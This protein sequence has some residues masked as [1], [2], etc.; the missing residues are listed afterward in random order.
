[1]LELGPL[2]VQSISIQIGHFSYKIK[3]TCDQW[4]PN[5]TMH[6]SHLR[7]HPSD[8]PQ[9]TQLLFG[10]Q[11]HRVQMKT[12]LHTTPFSSNNGKRWHEG[13]A[14]SFFCSWFAHTLCRE[15]LCFVSASRNLFPFNSIG[16]YC[17]F[18]WEFFK[19][20]E[21]ELLHG[22]KR[23][24]FSTAFPE[25]RLTRLG[26]YRKSRCFFFIKGGWVDKW[27]INKF[28]HEWVVCWLGDIF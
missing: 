16:V 25:F 4:I 8:I 23:K 10:N 18:T 15:C 24:C 2:C 9:C 6:I 12:T 7:L 14:S 28:M 5:W 19:E 3:A 26:D 17:C 27:I 20:S 22:T 13:E 1:M 11:S 21:T